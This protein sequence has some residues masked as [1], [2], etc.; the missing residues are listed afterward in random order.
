MV[1]GQ[2]HEASRGEHYDQSHSCR[3]LHTI[4]S[5]VASE[6]QEEDLDGYFLCYPHS[7]TLRQELIEGGH[8]AWIPLTNDEIRRL[9]GE[10]ESGMPTSVFKNGRCDIVAI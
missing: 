2:R 6:D 9:R 7:H 4:Q 1:C 3:G 8:F 10:K 5:L